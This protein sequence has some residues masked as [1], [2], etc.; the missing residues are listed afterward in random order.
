MIV[1]PLDHH[2]HARLRGL[3]LVTPDWEDTERLLAV[4]ADAI[5]GGA[6]VV[7]YRNKTADR[8]TR[9]TQAQAL[10]GLCERTGIPF[11]IND[12]VDLC[13]ELEADGVHLGHENMSLAA[14]RAIL[15]PAR[16]I[17]VSCYGSIER[18]V[19]AQANGATYVALGGF[20]PSAVKAYPVTTSIET[21]RL[22]AA[23]VHI[24][25][26]TIGGMSSA[27]APPLAAAGASMI[28]AISDIYCAADP[29]AAAGA[30][31]RL[32]DR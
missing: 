13:L 10:K 31:A 1:A 16:M 22:T 2:W 15:G 8:S 17:G 9:Q 19:Q 14:A 24:P 7:Q 25:I 3:Y 5:S 11:V 30:L 32:L 26:A 29:A 18:A 27:N 21:L 20:F 28:A 23:R 4:T 12:H 6:A